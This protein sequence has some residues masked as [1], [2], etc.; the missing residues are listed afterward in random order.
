M[1]LCPQCSDK[2]FGWRW[3]SLWITGLAVDASDAETCGWSVKTICIFDRIW[4]ELIFQNSMWSH[5]QIYC[6]AAVPKQTYFKKSQTGNGFEVLVPFFVKWWRLE[7]IVFRPVELAGWGE[8]S[9][10]EGVLFHLWVSSQ[11]NGQKNIIRSAV[12]LL[13][14]V[15]FLLWKNL[16]IC[17]TFS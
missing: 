3:V 2:I 1:Q 11:R 6:T 16:F 10:R 4:L 15:V 9:L 17:F 13:P 12:I 5:H 14:H 7:P 8:P